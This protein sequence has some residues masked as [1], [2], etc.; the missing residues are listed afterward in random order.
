M[1]FFA[2][3][4]CLDLMHLRQFKSLCCVLCCVGCCNLFLVLI[5]IC[6]IGHLHNEYNPSFVHTKS[7]CKQI[8]RQGH[9]CLRPNLVTLKVLMSSDE[10]KMRT[11]RFRR[12]DLLISH[13]VEV[14]YYTMKYLWVSKNI[15]IRKVTDLAIIHL[16]FGSKYR[17]NKIDV[18]ICI[19]I[20]CP[21]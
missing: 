19:D 9:C 17:R 1:F 13:Y 10:Y 6:P 5:Y 21:M 8:T 3:R 12:S 11:T 7:S 14:E 20:V 15:R 4:V 2:N 16:T 18:G